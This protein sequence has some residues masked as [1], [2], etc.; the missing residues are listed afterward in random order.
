MYEVTD[1]WVVNDELH[2]TL[3]GEGGPQFPEHVI[4]FN[5]LDL[6]KTINVNTRLGFRF[7]LRDEPLEQYLRDH[8]DAEPPLAGP[9]NQE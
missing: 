3:D 2:F 1:Y 7:V 5:E 4:G 8:P 6:Q 9:P